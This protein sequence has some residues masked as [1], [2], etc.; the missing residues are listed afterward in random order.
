MADRILI[1]DDEPNITLS[2]SSLLRDEGYACDTAA[3]AEEA[4]SAIGKDSYALVLLD[5]NLPGKSGKR[6]ATPVVRV[7][8]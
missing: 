2:F 1:V 4:F 8:P 3:T 5:L 7:S 6:R